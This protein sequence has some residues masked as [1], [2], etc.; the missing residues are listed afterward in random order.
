MRILLINPN[1]SEPI[2]ARLAASAQ[3]ALGGCDTLTAVTATSGPAVVRN[4]AQLEEAQASALSLAIEH[5]GHND[6]I[7]LGISLDGAVRRMREQQSDIPVVGMTEAALATAALRVERIGLLT[8]GPELLPLY[9]HRVEQI[10]LASRVVGYEAPE[11]VSAFSME[12]PPVRPEVLEPL[13]SAC[14]RL[15][16]SGA[17]AV[18]LAGA[19]LCGYAQAIAGRCGMPVYDGVACAVRQALLLASLQYPPA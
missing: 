1:T 5:R 6:A 14:D 9:R 11:I 19:V 18:V 4:A 7:V 8:L 2:T 13:V 10:G 17:Q 3:A 16:A 15:Q 12:G